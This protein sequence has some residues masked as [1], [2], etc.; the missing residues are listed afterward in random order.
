MAKFT[1]N[2]NIVIWIAVIAFS[3]VLAVTAV[4]YFQVRKIPVLTQDVVAGT[5][6]TKS[7]YTLVDMNPRDQVLSDVIT[8]PSELFKDGNTAGASGKYTLAVMVKGQPIPRRLITANPLDPQFGVGSEIKQGE[9]AV[10]ASLDI[11]DAVGG[12][13][14]KGN[15]VDVTYIPLASGS[16]PGNGSFSSGTQLNMAGARTLKGVRIL[17]V[18]NENGMLRYSNS[19]AS[20]SALQSRTLTITF[21]IPTSALESFSLARASGG[22]FVIGLPSRLDTQ[23]STPTVSTPGPATTTTQSGQVT[24]PSTPATAS[25]TTTP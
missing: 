15:I 19:A 10:S 4:M 17:E 12:A 8:D 3:L 25:S 9:V 20:G 22:R 21:A 5:Q 16:T 23:G 18:R 1:L 6:I 24:T 11:A 2:R 14:D 13:V 7:M